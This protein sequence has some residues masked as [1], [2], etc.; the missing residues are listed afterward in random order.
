MAHTNPTPA[1]SGR[2]H[3]IS[4]GLRRILNA[5]HWRGRGLDFFLGAMAVLGLAPFHIWGLSLL[6]LAILAAR[7]QHLSTSASEPQKLTRRSGFWFGAGYF[8]FGIFWIGAAFIARGPAY[9]PLMIPMVA[10]LCILL[11]LFWGFAG[12]LYGRLAARRRWAPLIFACVFFTTEFLRGHAFSGFPWNLPGYMFEAGGAI[13]QSASLIGIYGLTFL[14]FLLSGLLGAALS[15]LA[16]PDRRPSPL[17]PLLGAALILA[18]LFLFGALRLNAAPALSFHKNVQLRIVQVPFDQADKFDPAK[19]IDIVNRYL[20]MTLQPGL[21][22]VTHVIWPEG[23]VNG[24]ALENQPLIR[25]ASSIF[26][27]AD[28]S[29]PVWLTQTLR[30]ESRVSKA[31]IAIDDYYSSSAAVQFTK[32]GTATISGLNDKSKLVPFGEYVPGGK[33]L[34]DRNVLPLSTA[35]ASISAAPSK[36]LSTFS[37]LPPLSPQICYEI[38]FPGMTPH[39]E[40]AAAAQWILNQ[41]NDGWYGQSSGPRQHANQAAYRAIEEGLPVVRSAGNGISGVI[42]PYGRWYKKAEPKD[43]AALDSQLPKPLNIAQLSYK[44]SWLLFLICLIFCIM[45]ASLLRPVSLDEA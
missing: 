40:G 4:N 30:R 34:E 20:D 24:L 6:A 32:D 43:S 23:A 21:D 29:P 38:I 33:W 44:F 12:W 3:D 15:R 39:A 2:G 19:A 28:N 42:D 18:G 27:A 8:I 13:S 45:C 37:G 5:A 10:A 26:L 9:I 41:S 14:S 7:L 31:G 25:A 35:L 17:P 1:I 36:T 16:A 11:A 22:D